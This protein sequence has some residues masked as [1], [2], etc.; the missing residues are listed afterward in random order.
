MGD[1]RKPFCKPVKFMNSISKSIDSFLK[2]YKRAALIS[3][4]S[5]TGNFQYISIFLEGTVLVLSH[6]SFVL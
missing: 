6:S 1:N 3:G 5:E 2:N 4:W